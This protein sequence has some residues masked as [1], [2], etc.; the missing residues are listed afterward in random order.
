MSHGS[1]NLNNIKSVVR[2]IK[3]VIL[4]SQSVH[5]KW[6]PLKR[7]SVTVKVKFDRGSGILTRKTINKK[8]IREGCSCPDMM[9]HNETSLS[10]WLCLRPDYIISLIEMCSPDFN[11]NPRDGL[12]SQTECRGRP[13]FMHQ[14]I[15]FSHL[16]EGSPQHLHLTK[17][18]SVSI[19][20][21]QF[22]SSCVLSSV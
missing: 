11:R 15:T 4:N 14:V 7:R 2:L 19:P 10:L 12:G 20:S 18:S 5:S 6:M 21:H 16:I 3:Q 9:D 22:M 1:T 8:S 13:L 17:I